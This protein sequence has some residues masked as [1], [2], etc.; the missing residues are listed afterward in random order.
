MAKKRIEN[1]ANALH[2]SEQLLE[3]TGTPIS[4]SET[5][6]LIDRSHT[7]ANNSWTRFTV[8]CNCDLADKIKAIAEKEG[9]TIR[10][11]VEKF[12]KNGISSYEAKHGSVKCKAKKKQNID[13]VL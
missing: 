7:S 2:L 10:E 11:V 1:K 4:Q 5:P 8:I 13:D 6:A 12:F 9:F 3:R